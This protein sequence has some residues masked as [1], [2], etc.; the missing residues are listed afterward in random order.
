M[1]APLTVELADRSY[2]ISFEPADILIQR[3][4]DTGELSR[5][6]CI[7][8]QNVLKQHKKQLSQLFS[9]IRYIVPSGE[10]SKSFAEVEKICYYL[11]NLGIPRDGALFAIGGGVV[12]DL[13]GFAAAIYNRGIDFYQVP[14]TLLAM[15]DSSVGGKTGINLPPKDID[16][17]TVRGGKNLV[18]AFHQPKAVFI[19]IGFLKTLPVREFSAGM[20]EVIKY[21]MLADADLFQKLES[22]ETALTWEH[23]DLPGIIRRCCEIKADVVRA[24]EKET[25]VNGGRA[26]LNLGHTFAH[27]VENVAGYGEYLHGEAVGLGLIMA[28]R[29]SE[30]LGWLS[31]GETRRVRAL[32]QAY[33]L[34]DSLRLPLDCSDLMNAM[35]R[36]KK[37]RS[38]KLRFIAMKSLGEAVTVDEV[39]EEWIQELWR[40]FGAE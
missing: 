12:G 4:L 13:A 19:D 10:G 18:G 36:D 14:T 17:K 30:K 22:Y 25:A 20:A 40:E 29:L 37:V 26:L 6:I 16:G 32:V 21:G 39:S 3:Y 33:N 5:S 9:G 23:G 28:S 31:P 27:A 8:D 11:N 15:V 35:L 38:G 7:V 2:E 34:P 24:D 1:K